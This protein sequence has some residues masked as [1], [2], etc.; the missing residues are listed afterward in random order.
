M[1]PV[2]ARCRPLGRRS[3]GDEGLV[4][5]EQTCDS[6]CIAHDRFTSGKAM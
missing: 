6:V 3:G 2:N 1:G 4:I 5:I